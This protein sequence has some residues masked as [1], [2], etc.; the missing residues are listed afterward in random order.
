MLSAE[1]Q[2]QAQNHQADDLKQALYNP[3]IESEYEREGSDNN[4]LLGISQTIDR[5]N[6]MQ[7]FKQLANFQRINARV[8]YKLTLLSRMSTA[9][10]AINQWQSINKQAQLLFEQEIQLENLL[11]LVKK[12]TNNGDLGQLDAEMAYLS[13]SQGFGQ[14][15]SVQAQ[16]RKSQA[17][18]AEL[19]P[20]W[21]RDLD[22]SHFKFQRMVLS[23]REDMIKNH[24]LVKAAYSQWQMAQSR[25]ELAKKN[26][27]A[28]PSF[29]IQAG[30]VANDNL[31][32]LNFSMPLTLR[33]NFDSAYLAAS[34]NLLA[35]ESAYL[36]VLRKQKY[37]IQAS[38]DE[39]SEY[40]KRYHKWQNLMQG[41]DNNSQQLLHRQWQL[42]DINTT[43]YL[44][45]LQ[46][47]TQGLLAGIELEQ[48]Y[49]AAIIQLLTDTAQLGV[50]DM[51][52]V[53][54]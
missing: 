20:D 23:N 38:A 12:R 32:S 33:R 34:Q 21:N 27:K 53:S 28:D 41:R 44:L 49:K 22:L 52:E 24:P 47:R 43:N 51:T 7:S 6:K 25:A 36:S 13:L 15:A 4:Y 40:E 42:G 17:Q 30:K 26:K 45:S 8:N 10:M 39:L 31:L 18:L 48:Q 2:L 29:G 37:A 9:L 16:L 35:A 46:Q 19:L 11:A 5:S 50:V 1:A 3:T 54:Q 14:T